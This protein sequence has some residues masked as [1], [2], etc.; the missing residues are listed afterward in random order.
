MKSKKQIRTLLDDVNG[1]FGKKVEFHEGQDAL[2]MLVDALRWVLD[3]S[4]VLG[5]YS[6]PKK[7]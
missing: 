6:Y 3:D 7:K 2:N 4:D 1:E 5:P